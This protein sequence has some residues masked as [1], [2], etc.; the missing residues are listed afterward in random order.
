[1]PSYQI[2]KANKLIN[3]ENEI[4]GNFFTEVGPKA[5]E[6][7]IVKE[8]IATYKKSLKD[9]KLEKIKVIGSKT[10]NLNY[11]YNMKLPGDQSVWIPQKISLHKG[12]SNVMLISK[13]QGNIHYLLEKYFQQKLDFLSFT[14]SPK[15][16]LSFWKSIKKTIIEKGHLIIL[17]RVILENTL[18]ESSLVKELNFK[19]KNI[20]DVGLYPELTRTAKKVKVVTFQI[21]WN[22]VDDEGI[23]VKP[24]T[25]RVSANGSL[26][27][28]GQHPDER[29]QLLIDAIDEI[30]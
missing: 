6:S 27:I 28:Y 26:L 24:M 4:K 3:F 20:E 16:L 14:F 9:P 17:Q 8:K 29:F 25:V 5:N 18:I 23:R 15:Q 21:K 13:G 22:I 1:M 30:I 19:A 11:S 10:F 2:Y 12:H 7:E